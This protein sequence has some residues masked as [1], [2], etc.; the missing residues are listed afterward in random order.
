[1][2]LS[3]SSAPCVLNWSVNDVQN[4]LKKK[5]YPQE[6]ARAAEQQRVDGKALLL[7]NEEDLK[8]I[9]LDQVRICS[10]LE[11]FYLVGTTADHKLRF[12][13]IRHRE[14]TVPRHS[15]IET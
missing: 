3:D 4:W 1:M 2:D 7:L 8:S 13:A 15:A 6:V 10:L 12:S 5:K 11:Y 9:S 14:E